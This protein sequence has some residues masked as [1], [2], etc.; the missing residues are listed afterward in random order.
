[1]N[2]LEVLSGCLPHGLAEDFAHESTEH[3]ADGDGTHSAAPVLDR[4]EESGAGHVR[5]DG[6]RSFPTKGDL[7]GGGELF[8]DG[9]SVGRREAVH[10]VLRP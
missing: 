9:S 6:F 4:T 8:Q 5:G 3:F 10:H 2:R 1:M 7:H